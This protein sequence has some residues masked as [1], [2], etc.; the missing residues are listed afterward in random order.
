MLISGSLVGQNQ[1]TFEENRILL[2]NTDAHSLPTVEPANAHLIKPP[3]E[4]SQACE[5]QWTPLCANCLA[6]GWFTPWIAPPDSGPCGAP[7]HGWLNT[8][9]GFFTREYHVFYSYTNGVSLPANQSQD[10]HVGMYQLQLPFSR[11][12][13]MGLDVPFT[14]VTNR[15]NGGPSVTKFDDLRVTAKVML[16]ET[17][18]FSLST[19]LG[20]RI[21][22]GDP[23][24]GA[25]MGA[26]TP[27]MNWWT[28]L[29][30]GWSF[31]GALGFDFPNHGV[32]AGASEAD[33][34]YNVAIGRTVTPH[35]ATPFGDFTYYLSTNGRTNLD[36]A[37]RTSV[38][39]L[40]PGIRTHLGGN[41]FFLTALEV[42]V[43]S[44]TP[45]DDRWMFMFVQ[46]F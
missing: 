19:E 7:R 35:E 2:P 39:T 4:C 21:P 12:L 10:A 36:G 40:T 23:E 15:S 32:P 27:K 11:R 31:R 25:G 42:P 43:T 24:V 20:V 41:L 46:G 6:E 9:D 22:S 38:V 37:N 28:N 18:N 5:T 29:G 3:G 34:L 26:L 30:C 13:W 45:F 44:P 33:L 1:A 17:R 14:S 16:Q 8:A